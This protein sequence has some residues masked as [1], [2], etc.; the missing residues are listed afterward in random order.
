MHNLFRIYQVQWYFWRGGTRNPH[1]VLHVSMTGAYDQECYVECFLPNGYLKQIEEVGYSYTPVSILLG[2]F[3]TLWKEPSETLRRI[4]ISFRHWHGQECTWGALCKMQ[5]LIRYWHW[6]HFGPACSKRGSLARACARGA[7]SHTDRRTTA[8]SP[9][10]L[11][12][13]DDVGHGVG[14]GGGGQ[15]QRPASEATRTA[16]ASGARMPTKLLS[17]S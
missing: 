7:G 14:R 12:E 11:S 15:G 10:A 5:Y 9:R 16:G 13:P 6:Y 17:R 8:T 2:L 3:K 1:Q 4:S